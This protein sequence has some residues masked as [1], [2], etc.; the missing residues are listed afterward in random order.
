[1][2]CPHLGQHRQRGIEHTPEHHVQGVRKTLHSYRRHGAYLDNAGIID[3]NTNVPKALC[4]LALKSGPAPSRPHHRIRSE[5]RLLPRCPATAA[6]GPVTTLPSVDHSIAL[7]VYMGEQDLYQKL[8]CIVR[9]SCSEAETRVAS[10]HS[11]SALRPQADC[12]ES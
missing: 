7:N 12:V 10:Q 9:G 1:M 5:P 4:G 11:S 2:S 6:S 3:H 8:V